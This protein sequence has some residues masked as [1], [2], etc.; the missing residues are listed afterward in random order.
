VNTDPADIA[1]RDNQHF[2]VVS[3]LKHKFTKAKSTKTSDLIFLTKWDDNSQSW[4][5]F[6]ELR[7]NIELHKY[8]KLHR[9]ERFIPKQF[10]NNL[11]SQM[12]D[13]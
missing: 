1:N 7:N 3:I 2:V 13:I 8:L 10:K 5:S 12:S 6:H 11:T 4:I 9:M